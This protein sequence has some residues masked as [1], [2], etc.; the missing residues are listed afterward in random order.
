MGGVAA[1]PALYEGRREQSDWKENLWHRLVTPLG[2]KGLQA[3]RGPFPGFGFSTSC[4][5]CASVM[6]FS[7]R[8][9]HKR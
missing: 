8:M 5:R 7:L 1:M 2:G 9:P 6:T 4:F 3:Y